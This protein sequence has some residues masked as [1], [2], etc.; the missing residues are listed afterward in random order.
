MG[1]LLKKVIKLSSN[2]QVDIILK[3]I[4]K[5]SE[6]VGIFKVEASGEKVYGDKKQNRIRLNLFLPFTEEEKQKDEA[7]MAR[8]F[9]SVQVYL[10]PDSVENRISTIN[11]NKGKMSS[12][13]FYIQSLNDEMTE[14]KVL[15]RLKQDFFDLLIQ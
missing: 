14:E 7:H 8:E 3:A 5:F 1:K 10:Y 13:H 4:Q 9:R 11:A 2:Q 12:M 15:L 6:S